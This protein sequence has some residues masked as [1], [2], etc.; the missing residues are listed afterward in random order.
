[1]D[2]KDFRYNNFHCF[3]KDKFFGKVYKISLD[4]GFSCPNRDEGSPCIYCDAAGAGTGASKA[5]LSIKDQMTNGMDLYREHYKAKKFIAYFQA[6]SNTNLPV[7]QLKSI[8]DEALGF[9][10]VIGLSIGTRPDCV[11]QEKIELIEK[12]TD[13]YYVWVE[14]GLQSAK[15]ETLR[16]INRGHTFEQLVQAVQMTKNRGINIC[17]H[18]IIG[19]PGE[20][21]EDIMRTA[22]EVA[23]LGVD[24]IKIHL[25]HVVKGTQLEQEYL[26]GKIQVLDQASYVNMV[27]DFLE[28]IPPDVLVQRLTGERRRELLVAPD[29]CLH[30]PLVIR[31]INDELIRR[32]SRQGIKYK[33]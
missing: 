25:L 33:R 6:Y 14:Y 32:N 16:R 15:N 31:L 20:S 26:A 24:G 23:K 21:Y 5:G 9:D 27:C 30:K 28:R 4:A 19:L 3:L 8:Y 7:S 18:V 22:D 29:W 12:Y 17:L 13:N 2:Q 1:M 10:E 11:D